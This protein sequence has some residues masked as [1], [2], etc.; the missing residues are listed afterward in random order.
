MGVFLARALKITTK[1]EHIW[2]KPNPLYKQK[3]QE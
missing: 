1:R 2:A 3:E